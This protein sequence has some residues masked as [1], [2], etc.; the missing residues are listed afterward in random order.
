MME[1]E[2]KAGNLQEAKKILEL[3]ENRG[4]DFIILL[5]FVKKKEDEADGGE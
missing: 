3:E 2:Y 1:K 5:E 4:K